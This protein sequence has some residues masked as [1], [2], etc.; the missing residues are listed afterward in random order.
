MRSEI[1]LPNRAE[2]TFGLDSAPYM[3]AVARGWAKFHHQLSRIPTFVILMASG[4]IMNF[5]IG[6]VS[7]IALSLSCRT[8]AACNFTASS[9]LDHGGCCAHQSRR[10][11]RVSSL[12]WIQIFHMLI[13]GH[14]R[15]TT[16]VASAQVI[17]DV[18]A[19]EVGLAEKKR[20]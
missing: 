11:E 4:A 8:E 20:N 1:P 19:G 2:L 9:R 6:L 14:I 5:L 3:P 10:I 18:S 16:E 12:S 15:R 7:S 13:L 17:R